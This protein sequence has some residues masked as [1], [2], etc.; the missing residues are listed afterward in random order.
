MPTVRDWQQSREMWIRSLERQTSE[1]LDTWNR[2]I[3]NEP[4]EAANELRAWLTDRGVTGYARMLLVMERFGYPDSYSQPPTKLIERQYADRARLRP[5]YDAV[6]NAAS[7]CGKILIHA[8]KTYVSLVTPRRTFARVQPRS[9][10]VILGFRLQNLE[11]SGRLQLSRLHH[12]MHLQV[13]LATRDEV[14]AEVQGWLARAYL[15]N[16]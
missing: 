12:T 9:A 3:R 10:H 1:D 2:R 11:P 16:S 8:R 6:I 7:Q 4:L 14:D 5:V 13:V 15:E